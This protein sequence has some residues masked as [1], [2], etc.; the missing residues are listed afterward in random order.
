WT[1]GNVD[2]V[3]ELLK[4]CPQNARGWEWRYLDQICR[5]E[6]AVVQGPDDFVDVM[7][8]SPDGKWVVSGGDSYTVRFWDSTSGKVM[9]ELGE[10]FSPNRLAVSPD[11]RLVVSVGWYPGTA[12]ET[13]KLWDAATGKEIQE[14]KRTRTSGL[15]AVATF[16]PDGQWLAL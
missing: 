6:L 7:A 14:L 8:F 15:P 11:A 13:V 3:K 10:K 4:Q 12:T 2:R 1:A 16:S 9:H 5:R